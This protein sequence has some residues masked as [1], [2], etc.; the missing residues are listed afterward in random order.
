MEFI[1]GTP[2]G[3]IKFSDLPATFDRIW[4]RFIAQEK[5]KVYG[6]GEQFSYLN[7]KGR[8]F[9]IWTREQG[10]WNNQCILRNFS[11]HIAVGAIIVLFPFSFLPIQA[12]II[13]ILM[14]KINIAN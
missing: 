9:P 8:Q 5:E 13:V 12:C 3:K 1:N 14:A 6:A 11:G 7:L 2:F 10:K 4:V